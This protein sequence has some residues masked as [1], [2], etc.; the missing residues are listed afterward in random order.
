M[1]V[2]ERVHD[3]GVPSTGFDDSSSSDDWET[4]PEPANQIS[5]KD[6]RWGAAVLPDD[7]KDFKNIHELREET[8][9]Q[10]EAAA[11]QDAQAITEARK[12]EYQNP[13]KDATVGGD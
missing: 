6:Q 10:D 2:Y 13:D 12:N 1:S 7:A 8:K 5:E 4:D 9:K 3:T 11:K